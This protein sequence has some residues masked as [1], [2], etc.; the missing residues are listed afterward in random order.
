MASSLRWSRRP[1]RRW[2]EGGLARAAR[3]AVG[4]SHRWD[5]HIAPCGHHS[6]RHDS[7]LGHWAVQR[8][9]SPKAGP[10]ATASVT[11][12]AT[13][14]VP[15]A[16]GNCGSTRLVGETGFEPPLNAALTQTVPKLLQ[17]EPTRDYSCQRLSRAQPVSRPLTHM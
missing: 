16:A 1:Y 2:T 7:T 13:A 3:N 11:R 14:V 15:K 9:M 8:A 6:T 5:T 10:V 12:V 17:I 4:V